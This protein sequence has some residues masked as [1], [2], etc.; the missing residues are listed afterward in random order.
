MFAIAQYEDRNLGEFAPLV[1]QNEKYAKLHG[2]HH[3]FLKSG[4]EDYPPWWRKVFLVQELLGNYE[5]VLWVDSDAAIV[6]RDHFN[7]LFNGKHFMLSP[8]PPMLN[9]ESLSMFSAP[10]CAGVWGVRNT[11]E[12][13][14][15]MERWASS[16]DKSLWKREGKTWSHTAGVYGGFAYE[17]GSFEI[18]IW[19][20]ASFEEW[21]ENKSCHILNYLPKEDRKVNGSLCPHDVFAVHYW[22]GNRNHIKDHW[23]I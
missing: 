11:P 23:K 16:Y 13:R 5:A 4:W 15:L 18:K 7:N 20:C 14:V 10:F 1:S 9:S 6:G 17:Q 8:N 3:V 21:I 19:R 22:K 12:G 2:I